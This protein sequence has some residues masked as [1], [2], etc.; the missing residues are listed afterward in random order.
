MGFL[1][2]ILRGFNSSFSEGT[3]KL[4]RSQ[5]LNDCLKNAEAGDAESQYTIGIQYEHGNFDFSQ[6]YIEAA[7]WYRKAAEQ[8]HAGAQL[9]LGVLVAQ[10]QGVG[11]NCV[12]AYKWIELAKRGSAL[13][14]IAANGSQQRLVTY[15]TQEQIA[16]GKKLSREFVPK[17]SMPKH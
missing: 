15:M 5:K 7:K 17:R 11:P 1:T 12:E 16:E 8:G 14:K 4:P 13:D 6:D 9:Y 3:R 2:N 10:G